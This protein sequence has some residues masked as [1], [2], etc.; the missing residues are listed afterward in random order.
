[1]P[2]NVEKINAE[3]VFLK[4]TTELIKE[5]FPHDEYLTEE[6]LLKLSAKEGFDYWAL[7]DE[8]K[9]V[10]FMVIKTYENMAFLFYFAIEKPHRSNG[11]GTRAIKTL[12]S[13]YPKKIQTVDLEK[14]DDSADNSEQRERRRDF[15][16]R[17]GYKETGNFVS[18]FGSDY[19]VLSMDEGFEIETFK[20]M[21][22]DMPIPGF[23]PVYSLE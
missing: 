6:L 22:G 11:Y 23:E 17:N 7:L 1:M 18:Y 15:Y 19:E 3:S 13:L 16:F 9:Y 14:Q 4:R 8:D 2:L 10:G 5:A 12:K 21:L 20:K